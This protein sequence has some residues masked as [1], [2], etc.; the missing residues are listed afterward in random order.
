MKKDI[1]FYSNY[2]TYSKEVINQI[3]KTTINDNIIYVCVDDPN[4]QLPPFIKA[5]PT[6][7][8]VNDKKIVV[9][10]DITSW[11]KEK[12]SKPK[13]DTIQAYYG[14]TGNSYGA[15]FSNIDN[16]DEKPFISSYTFIGEEQK[17]TTPDAD[18]NGNNGNN[19]RIDSLS[20][21]MEQIQNQRNNDFTPMQ[22]R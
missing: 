6:I 18:N 21:K 4:I 5:V 22:R 10:Q 8:L 19:G 20:N 16:S 17:I 14:A 15:Q 11:I 9:D 13:D 12:I 2:C 3:S 7:Y 1:I